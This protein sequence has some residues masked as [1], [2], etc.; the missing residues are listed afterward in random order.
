MMC[1]PEA[2]TIISHISI[3]FSNQVVVLGDVLFTLRARGNQENNHLAIISI[4][5]FGHFI[6]LSS[7]THVLAV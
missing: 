6:V 4:S 1:F 3:S 7:T 2:Q 5:S